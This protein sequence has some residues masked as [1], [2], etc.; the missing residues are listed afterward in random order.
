MNAILKSWKEQNL[1][2][3]SAAAQGDRKPAP[4]Q[5]VQRHGGDLSDVE[6]E[7]VAKMLHKRCE[8]G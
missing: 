8:E 6:R 1:L 2:T 7:A 5:N 3:G 4:R